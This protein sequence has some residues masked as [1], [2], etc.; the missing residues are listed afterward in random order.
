ME[1]VTARVDATIASE[2]VWRTR[3]DV[4]CF[5]CRPR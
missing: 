4:G 2:G 3:S 5:V 1:R